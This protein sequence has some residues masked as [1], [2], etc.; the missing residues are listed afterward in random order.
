M[1]IMTDL[2]Q[3]QAINELQKNNEIMHVC[4]SYASHDMRAPLK[5]IDVCVELVLRTLN[6]T[7]D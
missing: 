2:T 6:L 5:A 7:E 4:Q 3:T 1:V